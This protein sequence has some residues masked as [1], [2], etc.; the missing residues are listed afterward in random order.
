[1]GGSQHQH[2]P[3]SICPG[4]GTQVSSHSI[5]GTST[6]W[7]SSAAML[8]VQGSSSRPPSKSAARFVNISAKLPNVSLHTILLGVDGAS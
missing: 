4:A 5:S 7:K 1:M 3:T 2:Q 6:S 8:P